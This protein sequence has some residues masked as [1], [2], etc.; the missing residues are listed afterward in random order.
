M[1]ALRFIPTPTQVEVNPNPEATAF[2]DDFGSD[3]AMPG[4][5]HGPSLRFRDDKLMKSGTQ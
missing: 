4:P 1:V 2:A 5:S 3:S